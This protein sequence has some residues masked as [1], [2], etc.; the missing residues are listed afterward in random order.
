MADLVALVL[1]SA[2]VGGLLG[3]RLARRE[4]EARNNPMNWNEHVSREFNDLVHPTPEQEPR[5]QAHLDRAV[6]E[7]QS[8]RRET[9]ARSTNVIGRLIQD[10]E[11]ELTTEQRRAFQAMKPKPEELDLDLLNT[12]PPGSRR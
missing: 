6:R 1:I 12:T 11:A 4:I 10:V 8:I 7:L 5:V 9:L 3:R 2:V